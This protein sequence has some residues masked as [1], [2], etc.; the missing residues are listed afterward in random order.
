MNPRPHRLV[1]P[2]PSNFVQRIAAAAMRQSL[3]ASQVLLQPVELG[4]EI[5]LDV[6]CGHLDHPIVALFQPAAPCGAIGGDRLDA[7]TAMLDI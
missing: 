7:T 5:A 6:G 1:P 3:G 2:R 4:G